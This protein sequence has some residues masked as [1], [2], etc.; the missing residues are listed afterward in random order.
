MPQTLTTTIKTLALVDGILSSEPKDNPYLWNANHIYIPYCSSDSWTGL[1]NANSPTSSSFSFLGSK[2]IEQVLESLHEDLP[3]DYS[4][5]DAKSILLAGD[6]AGATGAILNLDKVNQ[7]IE[8]KANLL[9]SSCSKNVNNLSLEQ[10]TSCQQKQQQQVPIVRGLADSG[11]F[12][13]NEPFLETTYLSDFELLNNENCDQ[14]RCTPLQSIKQ[15]MKHWNGQVPAAC[16]DRYPLEPWHC[17]FGYKAYQTLKTPLFVVQW[18]Y[19]E[20]QLMADH[21]SRP[22]TSNQWNYVNKVSNEMRVSLENVTALFAP[23]CLSHSLITK[24]SWNEININGFKLPH[25]LNTWEEQALLDT[26]SAI[27]PNSA[28]D[29]NLKISLVIPDSYPHQQQQ[30]QQHLFIKQDN[31]ST[32]FVVDQP[33]FETLIFD[34]SNNHDSIH[35]QKK[36]ATNISQISVKEFERATVGREYLHQMQ[37]GKSSTSNNNN[38]NSNNAARTRSRKRKRN[39][40]NQQQASRSRQTRQKN[41]FAF[42]N[43]SSEFGNSQARESHESLNSPSANPL[44]DLLPL[45]DKSLASPEVLFGRANRS[46]NGIN[47]SNG[48]RSGRS[49]IVDDTTL[50]LSNN[51][52]DDSMASQN[53]VPVL[54]E[55]RSSDSKS[56]WNVESRQ[57][58]NQQTTSTSLDS[59]IQ[60]VTSRYIDD[61]F[62][63]IDS[64]GSPQCNRDCPALELDFNSPINIQ[65]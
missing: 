14:I 16:F 19:D 7:F 51:V 58:N 18:L 13:D 5:Y 53:P 15:A 20:A 9:R 31:L 42:E 35:S 54:T 40:N 23:S 10:S 50:M 30:Q 63:F 28:T 45:L 37:S 56:T 3:Q 38:S 59:N 32:L 52:P 29:N 46:T 44:Q 41:T 27:P 36:E 4:L 55:N 6:S 47:L 12:L 61:R 25:I 64:C 2:I 8:Y 65:F 24:R 57:F 39:N 21:I 1:E 43:L 22:D 34:K 17:Y 26:S 48:G 11:W 49:T 62:R 33:T 60:Q